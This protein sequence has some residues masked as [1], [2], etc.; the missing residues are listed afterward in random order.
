MVPLQVRILPRSPTFP[1]PCAD[2]G[3]VMILEDEMPKT[4]KPQKPFRQVPR[5]Y[6]ALCK[7]IP[8]DAWEW[9]DSEGITDDILD[10]PVNYVSRMRAYFLYNGRIWTGWFDS[11][12]R[13]FWSAPVPPTL[14]AK[15]A[16]DD[17]ESAGQ[18]R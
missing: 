14:A 17:L 6:Y 16:A 8:E 4:R 10:M 11:C 7:A 1:G 13:H 15:I 5:K 18:L 3:S 2:L 12:E 9:A